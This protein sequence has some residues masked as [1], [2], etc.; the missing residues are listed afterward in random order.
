[1]WWF[2]DINRAAGNTAGLRERKTY[3]GG[4]REQT[5]WPFHNITFDVTPCSQPGYGIVSISLTSGKG[6]W[7]R[8]RQPDS[9]TLDKKGKVGES[10]GF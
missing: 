3:Q 10:N 5:A 9:H 8:E 6:Y 7:L 1:M 4:G 2:M